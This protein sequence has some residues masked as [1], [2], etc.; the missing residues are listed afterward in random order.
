MNQITFTPYALVHFLMKKQVENIRH[1]DFSKEYNKCT[2]LQFLKMEIC[3][4]LFQKILSNYFRK[5]N[6]INVRK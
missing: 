4:V 5:E 2:K 1:E 6:K 3:L